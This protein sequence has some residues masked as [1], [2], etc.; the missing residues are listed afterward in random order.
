M[1]AS[2][3]AAAYIGVLRHELQV[4][5]GAD[6]LA[7]LEQRLAPEEPAERPPARAPAIARLAAALRRL[8]TRQAPACTLEQFTDDL[9]FLRMFE[10]GAGT[11]PAD[12]LG[13]LLAEIAATPGAA[14]ARRRVAPRAA[15]SV[16]PL[17]PRRRPR[18]DG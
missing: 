5:H 8:R 18:G 9:R 12:A 11:W 6:A 10:G 3:L 13:R 1:K 2:E 14:K 16:V 7:E 15:G 4:P 17:R